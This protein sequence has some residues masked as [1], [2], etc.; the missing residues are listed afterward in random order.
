MTDHR[1]VPLLEASG[2]HV[3]RPGLCICEDLDLRIEPGQCWTILGR[4]GVGKT[5]LLHT[6]AGLLPPEQGRIR[7]DGEDLARLSAI[8][9]ARRRGLLTQD[10]E[11]AFPA[12]V[13]ETALA[14]RFPHLG[15]WGWEGADDMA[16]A[17]DALR[18]V[19]LETTEQRNTLTLS[20]GERRRLGIATLLTQQPR[21]ALLDEPSNHLDPRYQISLLGRLLEHFTDN[22]RAMLMVLHDVNLALRFSDHLL[23]MFG[24]GDWLAGSAQSLT[25]EQHLS[26]VYGHPMDLI[27]GPRGPVVLP[28]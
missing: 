4:N 22:A 15:R 9:Q 2:L 6:L 17:R 1:P 21:L 13:L 3:T 16:I 18:Q 25:D 24:D 19:G 12:T 23:L 8:E 26:R 11:I 14:G 10:D 5:T 7:V 28:R 27:P 20:G